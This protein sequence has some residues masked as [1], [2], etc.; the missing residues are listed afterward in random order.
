MVKYTLDNIDGIVFEFFGSVYRIHKAKRQLEKLNK[1]SASKSFFNYE[2][3][4]EN[5]IEY[6]NDGSYKIIT[7]PEKTIELW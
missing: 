7:Q 6:L 4:F 3:H 2:N 1:Y 5:L